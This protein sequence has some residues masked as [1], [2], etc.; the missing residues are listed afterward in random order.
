MR[1]EP[2]RSEPSASQAMPVAS[3]TAAPPEEPP[4]VRSR[5][6][7]LRVMPNTSLKVLA[8]APNSGVLDLPSTTP[9]AASMRWTCQAG[10]SRHVVAEDRRAVGRA[11][12]RD[13][14]QVLDQHRQT[15]QQARS[16]GARHDPAGMRPGHAPA[17]RVG[18]ALTAGSTAA[19]R[20]SAA[21]ISS[22]G[23]TSLARE[24]AHRLAGGRFGRVRHG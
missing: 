11:H 19:I 20:A 7:G 23:E 2:P 22:S 24:L 13:L 21:S 1:S 3:A 16:G 8:P 6:H 15:R 5:F 10:E 18:T 17:H 12:P 9:P 4:Q 14:D